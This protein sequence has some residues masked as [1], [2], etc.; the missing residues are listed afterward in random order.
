MD[1][2]AMYE[3]GLIVCALAAPMRRR[4]YIQVPMVRLRILYLWVD[5]KIDI[6]KHT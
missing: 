4:T 3:H 2:P 5:V 1:I 6:N